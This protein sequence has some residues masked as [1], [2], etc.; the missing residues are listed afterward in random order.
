[1][2]GKEDYESG[3][4]CRGICKLCLETSLCYQYE[5]DI[6][7]TKYDFIKEGEDRMKIN[8]LRKKKNNVEISELK[9]GEFFIYDGLLCRI[10]DFDVHDCDYSREEGEVLIPCIIQNNG[11]STVISKNELVTPVEVEINIIS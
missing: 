1:M 5:K 8:D 2:I 9:F 3:L 4:R 7:G 6:K 11:S 10:T